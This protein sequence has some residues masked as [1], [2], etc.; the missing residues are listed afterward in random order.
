MGI[1]DS[2]R[3]QVA[4]LTRLQSENGL[5]HTVL[6]DPTAYEELS[7]S[8]GIATGIIGFEQVLGQNIYKEVIEKATQGIPV[9][10]ALMYN[11]LFWV[12]LGILALFYGYKKFNFKYVYWNS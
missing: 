11:K 2:L 9:V 4:A 5:W 10:G 12:A 3:D 8:A 7:A 6:D 1:L